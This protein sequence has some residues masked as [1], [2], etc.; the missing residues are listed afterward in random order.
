MFTRQVDKN[1]PPVTVAPRPREANPISDEPRSNSL[2]QSLALRPAGIQPK[3]SISQPGDAYEHEADRVADRV[4]RMAGPR[5]SDSELSISSDASLKAQRKCDQCEEEEGATKLQR[6]GLGNHAESSIA[7]PAIVQQTLRAPGQPLDP[8]TRA[9]FEPRFGRDFSRVRV[10]TDAPAAES[11]QTVGALAYTVGSTIAFG[12]GQYRPQTDEG[13]QLLAH[14]LSHVVQQGGDSLT[15]GDAGSDEGRLQRKIVVGGRDYNPGVEK[16]SLSSIYNPMVHELLTKMHNG[17]KPPV[18]SFA[19]Y[20]ELV[21]EVRMRANIIEGMDAVKILNGGCCD[22]PRNGG[23]GHLNPQ[24]W[25]KEGDFEF[26]P[27][28][29]NVSGGVFGSLQFTTASDAIEA[30]FENGAGTELECYSM[31]VAVQYR[32]MLKTLGRDA[33]NEKFPYGRGI[34]ISR[35]SAGSGVHPFWEENIYRVDPIKDP[36]TDLMPGDWVKFQNIADYSSKHPG[37]LWSG[38]NAVYLGGGKFSGF[39]AQSLTEGQMLNELLEHYNR[40]LPPAEQ[41]KLE[42]VPGLGHMAKR[43]VMEK[44]MSE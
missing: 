25:S 35:S 11:A 6:K 23:T 13:R 33:F 39:G 28:P 1:K 4:M 9:F 22:Y 26:I 7:A 5:S 10:H 32:A 40:G 34:I 31:L 18:Y 36:K 14:E 43:P 8:A 17:G 3:L 19:S 42:D 29:M 16:D 2:W 44:I 38:E 27:V 21:N 41:K 24:Y 15:R 30:I 12:A 37:G 20:E